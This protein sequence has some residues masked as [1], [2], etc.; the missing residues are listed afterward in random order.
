[1]KNVHKLGTSRAGEYTRVW[2]EGSRLIAAGFTHY[3]L[4][5]REIQPNK[6]VLRIVTAKEWAELPRAAK[7]TVAGSPSRPIIDITGA[8]VAETFAPFT[9]VEVNY[10]ANKIVIEGGLPNELHRHRTN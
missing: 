9:T 8:S 10:L 6:I 4:F 3:K 7:G 2:L 1:M 5:S